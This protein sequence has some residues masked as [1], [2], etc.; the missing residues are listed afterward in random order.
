VIVHGSVL[1][2]RYRSAMEFVVAHPNAWS[3]REQAFLRKVV[4]QAGLVN[5]SNAAKNVRFV[6]E[7]EASVHYCLHDSTMMHHLKVTMS[8]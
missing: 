4:T 7:A 6:T 2:T 8:N 1:W 3:T 5:A